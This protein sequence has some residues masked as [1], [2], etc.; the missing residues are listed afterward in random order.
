MQGTAL[1]L[2][3]LGVALG[4]VHAGDQPVGTLLESCCGLTAQDL[5]ALDRGQ[6]IG[7]LIRLGDGGD[8][9]NDIAILGAIRLNVSK[10]A[11]LEWY[12]NV[13]N[14]KYSA[15]VKDVSQVHV[16]PKP[17]DVAALMLEAGDVRAL[18]DCRVGKCGLKLTADEIARVRAE[19][20]WTGA[21]L[22]KSTAQAQEL[23]RSIIWRQLD[24]YVREGDRALPQYADKGEMRDLAATFK[25]LVEASGYVRRAFPAVYE[26]L[27]EPA[28]GNDDILYWSTEG[29]GFGLKNLVNVIHVRFHQP[30]PGVAVIST[31]QL[32]ATHYYEGFL[33]I[34]VLVDGP[35]VGTSYLVYLNRSRIDILR[36]A[37]VKKWLVR[38]FAPG[39]IRKEMT[40]LKKQLDQAAAAGAAGR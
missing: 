2:L 12:R 33:G 8:G 19:V 20:D 3:L 1:L 5:A 24:R 36:D 13:S 34:S 38:R 26:R 35:A 23:V 31:K 28:V 32:R 21:A 17:E 11:Y 30:G 9:D 18:R 16:P 14:Y 40:A 22:D 7:R 29:Y 6:A 10:E 37:G 25:A 27:L 39:A 15:L 4:E